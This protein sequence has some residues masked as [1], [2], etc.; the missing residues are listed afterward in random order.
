MNA[1]GRDKDPNTTEATAVLEP[2]NN[3]PGPAVHRSLIG[4]QV[5]LVH[6]HQGNASLTS[7]E[8]VL[9]KVDGQESKPVSK[10]NKNE[11]QKVTQPGQTN[12]AQT[13]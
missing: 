7:I 10:K 13:S 11:N 2:D 12:P 6:T 5:E 9:T 8:M 4:K 3:P 1:E